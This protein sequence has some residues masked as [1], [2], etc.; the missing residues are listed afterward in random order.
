MAGQLKKLINSR[1][2]LSSISSLGLT[3]SSSC[4]SMAVMVEVRAM[5]MVS[6]STTRSKKEAV[7]AMQ[8]VEYLKDRLI[9]VDF[10]LKK[11]IDSRLE[12]KMNV[13][14][15]KTGLNHLN[16]GFLMSPRHKI[17]SF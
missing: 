3:R 9:S 10:Q 16:R 15:L 1:L 8:M 5:L 13:K 14:T 4:S 2:K 7:I 6:G 17:A 11:V 12:M